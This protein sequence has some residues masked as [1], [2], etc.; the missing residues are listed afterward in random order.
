M[1]WTYWS[2]DPSFRGFLMFQKWLCNNE[3]FR[4]LIIMKFVQKSTFYYLIYDKFISINLTLFSRSQLVMPSVHIF[5]SWIF[6]LN[7]ATN[8]LV[9]ITNKYFFRKSTQVTMDMLPFWTW[10]PVFPVVIFT[11]HYSQYLYLYP[12]LQNGSMS[13]VTCVLLLNNIF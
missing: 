6:S 7:Y 4:N 11:V 5:W 9:T 2:L 13:I 1:L 3:Y 10:Q 8:I 12:V